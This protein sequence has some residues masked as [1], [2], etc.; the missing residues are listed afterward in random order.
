[1]RVGRPGAANG[2]STTTSSPAL[3]R[4][5][6]ADGTVA[7]T[8]ELPEVMAL[9]VSLCRGALQGRWDDNLRTRTLAIVYAGMRRG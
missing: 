1:M 8:V 3:L 7:A 9:L 5:A 4:R 2:V 6:H